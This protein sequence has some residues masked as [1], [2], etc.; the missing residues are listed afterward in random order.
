VQETIIVIYEKEELTV[1]IPE[2]IR[3]GVLKILCHDKTNKVILGKDIVNTDFLRVR[4][5]LDPGIYQ[6]RV[7]SPALR[8]MKKLTINKKNNHRR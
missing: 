7:I 3:N 4:I 8:L 5:K 1:Q 2:P 6:I